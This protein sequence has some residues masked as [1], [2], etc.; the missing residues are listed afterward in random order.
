MKHLKMME[1]CGKTSM[2]DYDTSYYDPSTEEVGICIEKIWRY[3]QEHDPKHTIK[4]FTEDYTKCF[5][6][7]T[8]HK[9]VHKLHHKTTRWSERAE[10]I[11]IRKMTKERFPQNERKKYSIRKE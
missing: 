11:M 3:W 7:E 2:W 8:I 10:D 1:I 4:R 9:M 6:H 5:E